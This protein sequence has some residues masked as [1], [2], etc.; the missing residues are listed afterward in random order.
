MCFIIANPD[1]AASKD[2]C[3]SKHTKMSAL[4][5]LKASQKSVLYESQGVAFQ[6]SQIHPMV[7]RRNTLEQSRE[8]SVFP[9]VVRSTLLSSQPWSLLETR[10]N[11][12]SC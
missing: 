11:K 7:I 9:E 2:L 8:Q 12:A 5:L 1:S 6:Q 4:P 10:C 3:T